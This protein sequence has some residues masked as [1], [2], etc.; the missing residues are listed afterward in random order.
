MKKAMIVYG[1]STG[2]TQKAAEI[3]KNALEHHSMTVELDNVV[4]R[5]VDIFDA[6][7]D[8]FCLGVSTWGAVEDDVQ[9]DFM[10]FYEA[11]ADISLKDKKIAVFGCGDS[12]YTSFC[13]AVDALEK[14]ARSKDATILV[15]SLKIDG[16]PTPEASV[17]STWAEG[18]ANAVS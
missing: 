14:Q 5:D 17:V 11:M 7:Y 3:V 13:K 1:S 8:V 18:V 9:D 4:N 16:D 10:P 6:P 15:A 2:N 12:G